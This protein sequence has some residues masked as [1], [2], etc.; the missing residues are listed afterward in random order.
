[1][2]VPVLGSGAATEPA[3]TACDITAGGFMSGNPASFLTCVQWLSCSCL[4]GRT[5]KTLRQSPLC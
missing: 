3:G 4:E 1:M 2:L 5:L